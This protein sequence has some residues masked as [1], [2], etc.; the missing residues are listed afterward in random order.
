[1][2][3]IV[4]PIN[5]FYVAAYVGPA[6]NEGRY[7]SYAK[8]CRNKP[9]NYWEAECLFKRFGG[10]DHSNAAVA[11]AMA[12]LVAREHIDD[13]PSLECSSFGLDL[14]SVNRGSVVAP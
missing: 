1:M 11:L 3:K 2:E 5:G 4:G 10:E 6:A 7:A 8:I 12:T 9:R 13:L 14:F